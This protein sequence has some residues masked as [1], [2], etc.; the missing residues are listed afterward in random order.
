MDDAQK[1]LDQ[2]IADIPSIKKEMYEDA[3]TLPTYGK[4]KKYL[5][6]FKKDFNGDY[7]AT[8][9]EQVQSAFNTMIEDVIQKLNQ[10]AD[11][12]KINHD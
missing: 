11:K 12:V 10:D 8:P 7:T 5:K 2:I 9:E 3:K 4:A 6:D 1:W